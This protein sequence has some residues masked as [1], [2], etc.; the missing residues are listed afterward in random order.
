MS[1]RKWT[2][3][4]AFAAVAT[5]LGIWLVS[6]PRTSGPFPNPAAPR[7]IAS[8]TLATDEMLADLVPPERLACVTALADDPEISNV[9]GRFPANVTRLG[10]SDP[11]R[12][13]ALAPDLVCAA[14]YNTADSL[15]LLER[16][17]MAIYLN[18]SVH[19]LDE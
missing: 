16:S 17:G 7:R 1:W 5:G 19:G 2:G 4:L 14:P 13:I 11:E 15:K 10:N 3:W 18:E 8:L 6:A 12:I 9:A